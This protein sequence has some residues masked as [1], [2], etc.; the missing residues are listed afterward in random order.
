M[1]Y[2]PLV[3]RRPDIEFS[4]RH[5]HDRLHLEHRQLLPD[6]IAGSEFKNSPCAFDRVERV[7]LRDKPALLHERIGMGP[8]GWVTVHRLVDNPDQ[9]ARRR[10]LEAVLSL[11]S[12]TQARRPEYL[13]L[14]NTIAELL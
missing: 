14:L 13:R 10:V 8:V 6:T 1:N 7:T 9:E 5:S 12:N 11:G 3:I 2:I 4:G